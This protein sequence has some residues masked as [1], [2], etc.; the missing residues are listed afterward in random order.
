MGNKKNIF[1]KET[2]VLS[3]VKVICKQSNKQI[4]KQT[5]KAIIQN[6]ENVNKCSLHYGANIKLKFVF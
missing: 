3:V 6:V 4:N 5:N 2:I 1:K